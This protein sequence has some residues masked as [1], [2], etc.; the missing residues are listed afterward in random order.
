MN[1][2]ALGSVSSF[3]DFGHRICKAIMEPSKGFAKIMSYPDN[4]KFDLVAHD[5]ACGPCLLGLLLKFN[6]P[7]LIGISAFSNPP[8]T[9]DIVGGH[10]YPGYMPYYHNSYDMNMTFSERVY[11]AIVYFWDQ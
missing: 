4:F 6:Y 7:P 11:N 9:V 10:K 3:Y 5:F 2:S 8:F 1:E